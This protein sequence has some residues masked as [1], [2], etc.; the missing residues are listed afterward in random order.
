MDSI[1]FAQLR[2]RVGEE[3]DLDIPMIY[4]SDVFTMEQMVDY[5]VEQFG[6]A[7]ASKDVETSVNQ[8]L[9]EEDLRTVL[10][11]CLRNVLEITP[12][13]DLGE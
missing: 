5:L 1:M 10:L 11:S 2:K 6:S 7:P 4:L 9:D 13:E 12:D 3:F 8:P